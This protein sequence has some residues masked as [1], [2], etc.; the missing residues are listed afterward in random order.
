[1][2]KIIITW[3]EIIKLIEETYKIKDIKFMRHMGYEG[4]IEIYDTPEYVIG[5]ENT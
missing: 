4:D 5:K 3:D 1:M 2:K